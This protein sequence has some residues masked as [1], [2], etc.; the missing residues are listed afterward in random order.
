M[1]RKKEPRF[2][3]EL[4]ID[5]GLTAECR[6]M[7]EITSDFNN[8]CISVTGQKN[9]RWYIC[10]KAKILAGMGLNKFLYEFTP[11]GF[12]SVYCWCAFMHYDPTNT[13]CTRNITLARV[14]VDFYSELINQQVINIPFRLRNYFI[15]K[16][17]FIKRLKKLT[18]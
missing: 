17:T 3:D 4:Y 8:A 13:Y 10:L 2:V 15:F 7:C 14:G 5:H 18:L 11:L 6:I 9:W 1:L 16:V 12:F